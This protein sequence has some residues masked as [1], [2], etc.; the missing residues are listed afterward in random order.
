VLIIL[1]LLLLLNL[2]N[3]DVNNFGDC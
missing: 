2:S 3:F 1:K